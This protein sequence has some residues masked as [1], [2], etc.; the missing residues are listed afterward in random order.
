LPKFIIGVGAQKAGT[1]TLYALLSQHPEIDTGVKK[2]LHYFDR[3]ENVS[4]KEYRS[5]FKGNS[6]YKLDITPI[7]MFYPNC[8][9]KIKKIIPSKD[10]KIII[11]LRNPIERA[12]SHYYMSR[13]R[14]YETFTFSQAFEQEINRMKQCDFA[15]RE[16]SY[17]ERGKYFK[18]V[19]KI[20][21]N[22]DRNNVKVL[23][24]DD[25]IKDPQKTLDEVCEFIEISK[26]QA[27]T[28][29]LNKSFDV[30]STMIHRMLIEHSKA[31]SKTLK[32]ILPE[33]LYNS[34]KKLYYKINAKE[35]KKEIEPEFYEELKEY[36][37][38]DLMKLENL[39]NKNLSKWYL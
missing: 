30:K 10:L 34:L 28:I 16:F 14:G 23:L 37:R 8:I 19:S 11:I 24:F 3:V 18:Q 6:E 13:R 27:K 1:T 36:Y 5:K 38:E 15:F 4:L 25:L 32:A 21:K 26:I 12:L 39:I 17:F 31:V 33:N 35:P 7:Y 20:L 9:E 22:F 2:E 29:H